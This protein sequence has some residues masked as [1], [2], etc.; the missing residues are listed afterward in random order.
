[1]SCKEKK[2]KWLYGQDLIGKQKFRRDVWNPRET[3]TLQPEGLLAYI[4]MDERLNPQ[5]E[6]VVSQYP[7]ACHK[8]FFCQIYSPPKIPSVL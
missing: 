8:F 1:M 4:W 5:K 7:A 6:S 2:I 3:G